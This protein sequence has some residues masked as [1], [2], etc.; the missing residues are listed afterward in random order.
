MFAT[1]TRR[2]KIQNVC[3][4][5]LCD[6]H[7]VAQK[8]LRRAPVAQKFRTCVV[9]FCATGT[10]SHKNALLCDG[11]T[12]AMGMGAASIAR[13]AASIA[14]AAASIAML[15]DPSREIARAAATIA[16]LADPSREIARW[17]LQLAR[18]RALLSAARASSRDGCC[19]HGAAA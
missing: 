12:R 13:A 5:F 17:V 15:A 16:M 7:P 11:Q 14:R 8:C 18:A 4:E 9:S 3:C 19:T 1:G 6:G 2:T 10:L